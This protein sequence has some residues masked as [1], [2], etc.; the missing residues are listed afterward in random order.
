MSKR[1]VDAG[2]RIVYVNEVLMEHAFWKIP[3]FNDL[4]SAAGVCRE[5]RAI[6]QPI[7]DKRIDF[8]RSI[9]GPVDEGWRI[10][11]RAKAEDKTAVKALVRNVEDQL[12]THLLYSKDFSS[13]PFE[14]RLA[15]DRAHVETMLGER[16]RRLE[17]W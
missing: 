16:T 12:T 15:W 9:F 1:N 2:I 4:K 8:T 17:G 13:A 5:W 7:M 3:S 14:D 11:A 10:F 6:V